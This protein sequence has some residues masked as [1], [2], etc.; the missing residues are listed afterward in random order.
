MTDSGDN[1]SPPSQPSNEIPSSTRPSS[2]ESLKC[3]KTP[4]VFVGSGEK[5]WPKFPRKGKTNQKKSKLISPLYRTDQIIRSNIDTIA[6]H[7][8]TRPD[9]VAHRPSQLNAYMAANHGSSLSAYPSSA[10]NMED[11]SSAL[12]GCQSNVVPFDQYHHMPP[13][14][15]MQSPGVYYQMHPAPSFRGGDQATDGRPPAY[16]MAYPVVYPHYYPQPHQ[17]PPYLGFPTYV[18]SPPSH[19]GVNAPMFGQTSGYSPGYYPSLYPMMLG[20]GPRP[21]SR[22][23]M[24]PR[25]GSQHSNLRRPVSSGPGLIL[26]TERPRRP[27]PKRAAVSDYPKTI[28]D[29]PNSVNSTRS[30]SRVSGK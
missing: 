13:Q 25:S 4:F 11:I 17:Q 5:T 26:H 2:R 27:V 29:G 1:N 30:N 23:Q 22:P 10:L 9:N 18:Q 20:H 24:P 6:C 28:V 15:A 8:P 7:E 21:P 16:S 14:F 12:P 19:P 3:G